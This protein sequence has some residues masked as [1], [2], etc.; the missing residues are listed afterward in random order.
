MDIKSPYAASFPLTAPA[1][2]HWTDTVVTQGHADYCAAHGHATWTDDGVDMGRCPRCGT[3]TAA[4][5]APAAAAAP[6]ALALSVNARLD[7]AIAAAAAPHAR[8][9]ASRAIAYVVL[10]HGGYPDTASDYVACASRADVEAQL[11]DYGWMDNPGVFAYTVLSGQTPEGVIAELSSNP[12]PYPDYV[13][14]RGTRG[15]IQWNRA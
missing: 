6:T 10:P 12:D 15:G 7:A 11:V 1:D 14:E 5:V 4:T 2:A 3:V 13:V 8:R 9:R